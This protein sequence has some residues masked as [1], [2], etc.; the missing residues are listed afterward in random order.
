[1]DDIYIALAA[2][3]ITSLLCDAEITERWR[4]WLL[5]NQHQIG[6]VLECSF[7]TSW[8]VCTVLALLTQGINFWQLVRIPALVTGCMVGILL[9]NW[10]KSTY[11]T[12]E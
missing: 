12:E 2:G 11:S 9:I 5:N 10:A 3:A 6:R 4:T 1:M 8:Y 7:C